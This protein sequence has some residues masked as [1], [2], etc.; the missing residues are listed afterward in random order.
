MTLRNSSLAPEHFGVICS[1]VLVTATKA[2]IRFVRFVW[3][4]TLKNEGK[5]E[6]IRAPL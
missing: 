1:A 3:A 6:P 5:G 2:F 4:L